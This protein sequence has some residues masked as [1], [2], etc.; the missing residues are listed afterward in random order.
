[1]SCPSSFPSH[2]AVQ[3]AGCT[4]MGTCYHQHC[5]FLKQNRIKGKAWDVQINVF[6]FS[7]LFLDENRNTRSADFQESLSLSDLQLVF[8][9]PREK[10]SNDVERTV[11]S[12]SR[13]ALP[14]C[15][16][17]SHSCARKRYLC[18]SELEPVCFHVPLF[19]IQANSN[20]VN[21]ELWH[22]VG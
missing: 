15:I 4:G 13:Q 18:K 5:L 21:P 14:I 7:F 19:P 10:C 3:Q 2:G 20:K 12:L 11:R 22:R 1:M 16:W 8:E 17:S 9:K 6:V